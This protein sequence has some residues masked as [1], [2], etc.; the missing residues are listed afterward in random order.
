MTVTPTYAISPLS[1]WLV[2]TRDYDAEAILRTTFGVSSLTAAA[3]MGRGFASPERAQRFLNPTTD[4][5]YD[6][7]LLPD[8]TSAASAIRG[9]IER[10][11]LI[12]VH[13]DYDVDGVTSAAIFDRFLKLVG[14]NVITHVPHRMKEGYGIHLSA[15]QAAKDAGAKLFLTCD[16]GVSAH[17]Q[18]MAAH[19]AGMVVVVTDHH[20]IGLKIPEAAAIVN[21]HRSDSE[22]PFDELCGAGVVFKL[23][24]GLTAELGMNSKSFIDAFLDLAALGTIADIVPLIDENRII[25]K[26]GLERL[27]ATK[28]VG[29]RAL[30]DQ[31]GIGQPGAPITARQVGFQIGPRLNAAGRIDDSARALQLLIERDPVNA[32]QIAIEIEGI[33]QARR[34]EQTR[35]TELAQAIVEREGLAQRN[36]I[37]VGGHDWH[38]GVIGIVASR[39]VE[40]YKRPTF[41]A[42]FNEGSGTWKSSARSIPG[43]N[44]AQAIRDHPHLFLGG[45][46]HAAAAGCEFAAD[47]FDDI[48]NALHEYAASRLS[49]DDFIPSVQ[50]IAEVDFAELTMKAVNDLS[51]LE[52]FGQA[53]PEPYFVA[54][55]VSIAQMTPTKTGEHV[56]LLLRDPGGTTQTAMGFGMA[57]R[58]LAAGVGAKIDLLF[59]AQVDEWNGTRSVKLIL[60]DFGTIAEL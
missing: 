4:D 14:A 6:P 28:K 26:F 35:V 41:V 29:L 18:V 43:F 52:P 24:L 55:R 38:P 37:L 40:V 23:C 9:A 49:P 47:R 48:A 13:G 36:V 51:R 25:A 7:R 42:A 54:R 8:Y 44:L 53:N 59:Q 27:S 22:Y 15:V 10:K 45:G 2:K 58:V 57:E 39:I 46:G 30:F 31:A 12:F 56:R 50:A 33:N 1:R 21:P 5:L 3:L 19:E 11:E 60:K 17:E 20:S 16:C 34:A 32:T